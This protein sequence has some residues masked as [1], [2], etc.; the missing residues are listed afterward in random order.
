MTKHLSLVKSGQT[1]EEILLDHLEN[2]TEE[3]RQAIVDNVVITAMGK[4]DDSLFCILGK[5]ST[6]T[7]L[8]MLEL[9]KAYVLQE[10]RLYD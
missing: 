10:I 1:Y 8:G 6:S 3:N 7:L 4:E 2:L 9:A 5:T